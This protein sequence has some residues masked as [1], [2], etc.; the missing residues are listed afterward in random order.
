MELVRG[1]QVLVSWEPCN[2]GLAIHEAKMKVAMRLATEEPNTATSDCQ[3]FVPLL[4]LPFTLPHPSASICPVPRSELTANLV[5]T[6]PR[7]PPPRQVQ[8]QALHAYR[9]HKQVPFT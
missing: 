7:G 1:L 4:F 3:A 8:T 5:T 9:L 6:E 2:T